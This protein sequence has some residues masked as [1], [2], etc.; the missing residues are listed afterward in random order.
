M[1]ISIYGGRIDNSHD[2]KILKTYLDRIVNLDV[3]QGKIAF[4]EG[5]KV[6]TEPD[7]KTDVKVFE[8]LPGNDTPQSFGLPSTA[9]ISVQKLNSI[10]IVDTLRSINQEK[11]EKGE[12]DP[13]SW[14]KGMSSLIQLWK[15][16]N[17]FYI[18][19]RSL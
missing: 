6:P 10:R 7:A 19:F 9:D 8:A 3:L 16:K 14:K 15:S 1:E 5:I 12:F 17:F 4:A 11:K 2:H 13:E 18:N